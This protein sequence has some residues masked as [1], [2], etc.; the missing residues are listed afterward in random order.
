MVISKI[1]L[2][3]KRRDVGSKLLLVTHYAVVSLRLR[4]CLEESYRKALNLFPPIDD[5]PQPISGN[6]RY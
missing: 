4:L 2:R 5:P 6:S 3:S 1:P